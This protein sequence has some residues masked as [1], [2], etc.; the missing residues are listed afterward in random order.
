MSIFADSARKD[1]PESRRRAQESLRFLLLDI[2][3]QRDGADLQHFR[4]V[5]NL[6]EKVRRGLAARN[7]QGAVIDGHLWIR[8]P[9]DEFTAGERLV[10]LPVDRIL[11]LDH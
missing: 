11:N 3:E 8:V 7:L 10:V 5:E 4:T 9:D 2:A 6:H 1:Q